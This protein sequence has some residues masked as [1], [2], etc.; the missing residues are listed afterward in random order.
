[1]LI[2]YP[3]AVVQSKEHKHPVEREI[4]LLVIHGVLHLLGHEDEDEVAEARMRTAEQRVLG[5]LTN[6]HL[7]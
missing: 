3:R 4:A 6:E 7:L 2:S 5:E 1:V